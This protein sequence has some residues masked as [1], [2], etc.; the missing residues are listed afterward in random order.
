MLTWLQIDSG[1]LTWSLSKMCIRDS[2]RPVGSNDVAI[3]D[4]L[5]ALT[6]HN[7]V[8]VRRQ[9]NRWGVATTESLRALAEQ[10]CG[11]DLEALFEEWVY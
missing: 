10:H 7:R 1:K 6:R 5:D 11:C 9:E 8:H 2:C 4:R 3:K